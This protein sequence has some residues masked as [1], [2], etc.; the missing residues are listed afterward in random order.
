MGNVVYS[1]QGNFVWNEKCADTSNV[2]PP[3][4]CIAQ[5][6]QNPIPEKAKGDKTI[7]A[8]RLRFNRSIT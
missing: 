6:K 8:V 4:G 1:V 5:S 2:A 3:N 7:Q